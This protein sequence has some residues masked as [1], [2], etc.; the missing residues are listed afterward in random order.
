MEEQKR[1]RGRPR[2]NPEA[3]IT[4]KPAKKAKT[5]KPSKELK[6]AVAKKAVKLPAL[7]ELAVKEAMPITVIEEFK[8]ARKVSN[9]KGSVVVEAEQDVILKEKGHSVQFRGGK[10]VKVEDTDEIE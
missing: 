6:K 3:P 4:V 7:V 10:P 5:I 1:K 8:S 9:K 2:K